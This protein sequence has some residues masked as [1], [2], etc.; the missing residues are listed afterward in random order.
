MSLREDLAT[1]GISRRAR[2]I[3]TA[4]AILALT[5]LVVLRIG[6]EGGEAITGVARAADGD[7]LT[8][9][10]HRIRLSGIDT[11]ELTQSCK[12]DGIDWKC[13]AAARSRLAELLRAGPV[14]CTIRGTDK[15][16][17]VLARCEGRDGDLGE[18]MVR[19]GLAVAYG[20]YESLEQLAQAER[21]G[22]WGSTFDRPQDWRR[23]NGRPQEDPNQTA[24]GFLGRVLAVLGFN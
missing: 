1:M 13:G 16:Q 22:L 6:G 3:V 20:D 17:R 11:P 24:D 9:E 21:S 19:E 7:T 18:R 2:D 4:A 10:G 8:L 5:A 12:R 15:Y 14:T 23:M